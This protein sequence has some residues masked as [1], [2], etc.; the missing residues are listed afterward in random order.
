MMKTSVTFRRR[1]LSCSTSVAALLLAGAVIAGMP[2]TAQANDWTGAVS[3][4]WFTAGNWSNIAAVPTAGDDAVIDT[5]TPN[6]TSISGGNASAS[7]VSIGDTGAGAL[8]VS[9]GGVLTLSS[10]IISMIIGSGSSGSVTVTGAGS[11]ISTRRRHR[12]RVSRNRNPD[13]LEWR[14]G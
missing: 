13:D 12:G 9:N 8:Q 6:P 7:A 10:P 14:R 3:N 4:D 11:K 2:T 1:Q 5:M